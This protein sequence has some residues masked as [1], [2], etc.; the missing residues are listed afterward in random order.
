[1]NLCIGL[2]QY[3]IGWELLLN[4]LGVI[5]ECYSS[6]KEISPENYSVFILNTFPD[7]S[8]TALL[9][10]YLHDGGCIFATHGCGKNIN[11]SSTKEKYFSSLSPKKFSPFTSSTMVDIF[12]KG[13]T[14][15]SSLLSTSQYGKGTIIHFPF[16][17]HNAISDTRSLRK[18]FYFTTERLPSEVVVRVSKGEIRKLVYS[19][20]E[21]LHHQKNLPFIH[22]WF[23]PKNEQTIFTFRVDSDKGNKEEIT[24]LHNV[25]KKFSIPTTWFLDVKSH[26]PWISLFKDFHNQQQE[27][28]I[29][30]YEHNT[31]ST[32][33]ENYQNFNKAYT[34][35]KQHQE[36]IFGASAPYGTWNESVTTAF[37]KIGLEYSSEF[38]LDYD[39]LPFFPII[40]NRF[41]QV[42]QLPIHPMCVGSFRR[43]RF[44]NND[45]VAYYKNFIEKNISLREPIFLY[46]H[47]THHHWEVF[48]NIFNHI[49]TKNIFTLSYHN[50]TEWWKK[51]MLM[52]A[53]LSLENET[54]SLKTIITNNSNECF[55]R[56]SFPSHEEAIIPLTEHI[57]LNTVKKKPTPL[58]A[59][60]PDDIERIRKFDW[61][62]YLQNGLDF[63]YRRMQ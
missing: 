3:E 62:H 20:L 58:P 36:K 41:S 33:E 8:Q 38:S 30:C 42:L 29:H 11:N 53:S 2:L 18:N 1:M 40:N 52:N 5:W 15:S 14:T 12:S 51:R 19:S 13:V 35:L 31:Y 21:F 37:E 24:M 28:G 47:P 44:T 57:N 4:Q 27:I 6:E 43:A 48:E 63:W 34:I 7:K 55:W 54:Q 45:M 25:C 10:K 32:F 61:R 22:K 17:V 59:S 9:Q 39:N 16:D 46:H 49:R 56:I 50:Y 26:E 60:P 23:Y